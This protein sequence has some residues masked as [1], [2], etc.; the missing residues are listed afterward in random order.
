M[1][2]ITPLQQCPHCNQRGTL[3]GN[4]D[5]TEP[6]SCSHCCGKS[7]DVPGTRFVAEIL[8]VVIGIYMIYVLLTF[9][10]PFWILNAALAIGGSGLLHA[11]F[12]PKQKLIA[13]DTPEN[14]KT[15]T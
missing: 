5:K 1:G 6:Y 11:A 4:G 10:W 12:W 2:K 8:A 7:V 3:S 13:T 14:G 15:D 9:S